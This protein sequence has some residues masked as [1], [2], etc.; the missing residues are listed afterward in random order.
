M[1][2]SSELA[3]GAGHSFEDMV[4]AQYLAAMLGE[5]GAPGISDRI[6]TR[7]AL[8]Q[9]DFGEPLDDL[10]VDFASPSDEARLSLQLKRSLVISDAATN[11]DLRDIVRDGWLTLAKTG[12]RTDIDRIG[13]A[14][15]DVAAKKSRD[16]RALCD[17][18]RASDTVEHFQ[19]RFTAA[20]N[21]SQAHATIRD[22]I[23]RL[24]TAAIG[25]A[26]TPAELFRFLRH[27]VLLVFDF[28]QDG[29]AGPVTVTDQLR[30][31]LIPDEAAKAPLLWDRLCHIARIGAGRSQVFL[32]RSVVVKVS[33]VA[34]L[35][36][37][38]SLRADIARLQHVQQAWLADIDDDVRGTRLA[39]PTAEA[40]LSNALASHRFV[41]IQG[42][43]GS[44]KSVLLRR[45]I[46]ED[47]QDSPV[48][49]LKS[50]RLQ[51]NS[52]LAFAAALG[53]Q[54]SDPAD[55]LA[56]LGAMGKSRLF[57]D[58]IDRVEI[59]N[60][61]V[62]SDLLR[63]II[64]DP[65]LSEWSVVVTLR[66]TGVEPLRTWLPTGIIGKNGIGVAS[67]DRLDDAEAEALAD[68]QPA[69]RRLLFGAKPVREIV[70]RPFFAKILSQ[71]FA[72]NAGD[73]DF[74]PSSEIDLIANWWARGGFNAEGQLALQRQ[75]ALLELGTRRVQRLS[76]P[77]LLAAL[78]PSTTEMI[79]GLIADGVLQVVR[80]GLSVRFAHD[81]F[82]EWSFFHQLLGAD[83]GWVGELSAAGEPPVIGRVVELVSQFEAQ[84]GER[85][86][87]LLRQAEASSVRS[88]WV[89]AWLL[90]PITAP[91]F[92]ELE[93][94][95]LKALYGD[96][97]R[98]LRK[99]LVWFQA[100]RTIP[101]TSILQGSQGASLSA[102]ARIRAADL[103]GWPSDFETWGRLIQLLLREM[104][105]L[106]AWL[107]PE[108]ASIFDVWQNAFS[109]YPN[110]ISTAI[111]V[112]VDRWL[113]SIESRKQ[114]TRRSSGEVE[115]PETEDPW[116]GLRSSRNDLEDDLRRILLR[117][118]RSS[119]ALI[120]DYL[121]WI[122]DKDRLLEE[123]FTTVAEWSPLLSQTH[124]S[125]LA[126]LTR[127]RLSK[128]L[129]QEREDRH[130]EEEEM[131]AEWRRQALAKPEAKRTR[132]D[133]FAIA[134][135]FS[136]IGRGG[137][138]ITEWDGLAVDGDR[139]NYFPAS[140]LREP[141]KSLFDYA[142]ADAIRLIAELSNHAMK[143]WRQLHEL[144]WQRQATPI[145]LTLTFPWGEQQFWG[146][147]REYL[148]SRGLWAP[149]PL[150][151]AYLAMEN[152]IVA[153]LTGGR[154]A[155]EIIEQ[156][157]AGNESV[158]VVQLAVFIA[159]SAGTVS[160]TV[161]PLINS[162]RVWDADIN[163][164]RQEMSV[165]SSS[166]IG[167]MQQSDLPHALAVKE[168]NDRPAHKRDIRQ[169]AA[170]YV[171]SNDPARSAASKAAISAFSVQAVHY[172]RELET[173]AEED[174]A[175]TSFG[176]EMAH[177]A[178]VDNYR[179]IAAEP[180][181]A[182][183]RI[184]FVNPETETPE[185]QARAD[186][187]RLFLNDSALFYWAQKALEKGEL[188]PEPSLAA[189]IAQ[190]RTA[191]DTSLFSG[192]EA[193]ERGFRRGAVAAVAAA[194]LVFRDASTSEDRSWA[195]AIIKRAAIMPEHRDAYWTSASIN[196]WHPGIFAARALAENVRAD[197]DVRDAIPLLFELAVHPLDAVSMAAL[198]ALF[199]LWRLRP[200]LG[201]CA[202]RLGLALCID[203]RRHQEFVDDYD[204]S[205]LHDPA[206][207]QARRHKLAV[208]AE[209][210]SRGKGAWPALELP[211]RP[212][213]RAQIPSPAKW[214]WRFWQPTPMVD[215]PEAPWEPTH[216][217]WY[218]QLGA[219]LLGILPLAD[220]AQDPQSRRHFTDFVA[221]MLTW[222][223]E[224]IAP[225]WDLRGHRA[226]REGP[227]HYE[228]IHTFGAMLGRLVGELDPDVADRVILK[229]ITAVSGDRPC[230]SLLAPLVD[231]FTRAHVMDPINIAPA[232]AIVL[233]SGAD[234]LLASHIFERDSYEAGKL[235]ND[236]P[237]LANALL[238]I[239]VEN[240]PLATR[241]ANG[242]WRDVNIVQPVADRLVRAA[243]WSSSIMGK[244]LTLCER[245]GELYPAEQF[246]DEML[247]VLALGEDGLSSWR[248]TL[249]AAR[250]AGRVQRISE[251]VSPL[252]EQLAQKLLRILD[253]LIDLG[254]RRS[255]A[256]QISEA[257]REIKLFAPYERAAS[258]GA[259]WW[260]VG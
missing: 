85:W 42:L 80:V 165:G 188:P 123:V 177:W 17:F 234:R 169:L 13:C 56:E 151:C 213:V 121:D 235:T 83:Q 140:P 97:F 35:S 135:M 179:R 148:W 216:E 229:P 260:A 230:F 103:L 79:A 47:L 24:L 73:Q 58:G 157:L 49:F 1:A 77:I 199:S 203:R 91:N 186:E 89:R 8:Q 232:C 71:N 5:R 225:A 68:G 34:R 166:Q 257:F 200:R 41:Q 120:G 219:K 84:D 106:P 93:A 82:F 226:D 237:S 159:I 153:E 30:T 255:A 256:L 132:H 31:M 210:Q 183:D 54:H 194:A 193:M 202:L 98:L 78:K 178:R 174:G 241:F 53:L 15:E 122:R 180:E 138:S 29:A 190:A 88:Q 244:Y 33:T 228:W 209:R 109:S 108:I 137:F 99:L 69:L 217:I 146:T 21:A 104:S 101:N 27:F 144:D 134:G 44:G 126:D 112:Q 211:G 143:A 253:Q 133:E 145:P 154:A 167:F 4:T 25:R 155:D 20:G 192:D 214:R 107:V 189:A 90:G 207:G 36:G 221:Q 61:G 243:G 40:T 46:E 187:A 136:R 184:V 171:L 127:V 208:D 175:D 105:V 197:E 164:S 152:W 252:P 92:D 10:I 149:K 39:R 231:M 125:K 250:I 162:L 251:Q 163:R 259:S 173:K 142:P 57:I 64:D 141:F 147:P 12:F 238:F 19:T 129:P 196:P 111:V 131:S 23:A 66:D 258:S 116:A 51:G 2:Q 117:S 45:Q 115:K 204:G 75:M 150:A 161:Q 18:A 63:L 96:D 67:V 168:L 9:R 7:V 94:S 14:T 43:A 160:D 242:D 158:A 70:R 119:P 239:S 28:M 223:I 72:A 176:R 32:R 240:A 87:D 26:C 247:A 11:K 130:R 195:G 52:W 81:I 222:T 124:A 6:V 86:R 191:D 128:E 48:L 172:Y 118:A 114:L 156:I 218:S 248:G 50:D 233:S 22:D 224:S 95:Y 60:R 139:M 220:I 38:A 198:A 55:L 37:A 205:S 201:W 227:S 62:I 74:E 59:E 102:D 236:M 110:A 249:L 170:S 185:F 212:W 215:D 100:E 65:A 181:E 206:I 245:A 16:L 182:A 254:D 113:R 246:A 3:G 76:E